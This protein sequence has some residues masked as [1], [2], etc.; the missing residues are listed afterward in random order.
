MSYLDLFTWQ[1]YVTMLE[2]CDKSSL[3]QVYSWNIPLPLGTHLII[4]HILVGSRLFSKIQKS[5]ERFSRKI[6]RFRKIFWQKIA[7]EKF[8]ICPKY[9]FLPRQHEFLYLRTKLKL[10]WKFR[11]LIE[12]WGKS[13]SQTTWQMRH[14]KSRCI[15][16]VKCL[17]VF[18]EF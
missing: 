6:F 1:K 18:L 10:V 7:D 3:T 5:G 15:K 4:L 9:N 11:F 12:F 8:K 16:I 2:P 17:N 13:L 14:L